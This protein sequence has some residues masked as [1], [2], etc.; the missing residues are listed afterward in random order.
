[1]GIVQNQL[2]LSPIAGTGQKFFAG[3]SGETGEIM[4]KK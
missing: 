3:G 4:H 2:F 1:M